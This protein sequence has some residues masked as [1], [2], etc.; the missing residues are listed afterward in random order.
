MERLAD[1]DQNAQLT[2]DH[3]ES[4]ANDGLRTL[5]LG[6]RILSTEEYNVSINTDELFQRI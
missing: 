4:F 1:D 6:Y 2:S 5:C 3:L